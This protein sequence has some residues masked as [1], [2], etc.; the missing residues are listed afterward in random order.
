M[1]AI[2]RAMLRASATV[3]PMPCKPLLRLWISWHVHHSCF[4]L[5]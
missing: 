3:H 1:D 4:K 5:H 2:L